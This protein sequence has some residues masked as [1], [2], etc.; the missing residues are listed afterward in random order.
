MILKKILLKNNDVFG[1]TRRNVKKKKKHIKLVTIERRKKYLVPEPKCDTYY[2]V[3]C[4]VSIS[5]K[6]RKF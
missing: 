1:K 4:R 2:K 6:N 5:N 3:F